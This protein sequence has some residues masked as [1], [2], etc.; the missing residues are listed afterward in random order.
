MIFLQLFSKKAGSNSK[1]KNRERL[2]TKGEE[3]VF[4]GVEVE[5][6]SGSPVDFVLDLFDG[7]RGNVI[8]VRAFR[9][10]LSDEFVGVFD[11]SLLP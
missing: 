7:I 8:E 5:F 9:D 10:V 1:C 6:F 11:G 2:D 3:P 4:R